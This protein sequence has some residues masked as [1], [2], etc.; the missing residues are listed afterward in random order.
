MAAKKPTLTWTGGSKLESVG[1][2]LLNFPN[3]GPVKSLLPPASFIDSTWWLAMTNV[4]V[5]GSGDCGQ[6]GMGE[7]VDLKKR[8]SL[9]PFFTD[10]G[11]VSVAAGGLHSLALSSTGHVFTPGKPL[12]SR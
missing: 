1:S 8:P 3:R 12:S 7:D 5:F 4:Y 6:L 9:H 2:I 11:I 10:K